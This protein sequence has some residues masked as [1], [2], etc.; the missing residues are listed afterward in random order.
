M[1][2][3]ILLFGVE[4]GEALLGHEVDEEIVADLGVGVYAFAVCL[5][6]SLSE[7]SW[8]L[9]I[10]EQVDPGELGVLLETIPV[11]SVDFTLTVVRVY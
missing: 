10:E 5:S 2:D 8:V 1:D 3:T 4:L 6:D 7:D 9:R 11:A